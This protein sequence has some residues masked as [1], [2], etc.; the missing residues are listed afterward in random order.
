MW[1][2]IFADLVYC[3]GGWNSRLIDS[4]HLCVPFHAGI[5]NIAL[6]FFW[7]LIHETRCNRNVLDNLFSGR[8]GACTPCCMKLTLCRRVWRLD[9]INKAF[10]SMK[11]S[12][13]HFLTV[14]RHRNRW[15]AMSDPF[16]Q[17]TSRIQYFWYNGLRIAYPGFHIFKR[18][19]EEIVCLFWSRITHVANYSSRENCS[20][21]EQKS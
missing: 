16:Y 1:K 21:W 17:I 13:L 12:S 5:Y 18:M 2:G 4:H 15:Y 20:F 10:V 9:Q 19:I 6:K 14:R 8:H 11:L 3:Q 7:C